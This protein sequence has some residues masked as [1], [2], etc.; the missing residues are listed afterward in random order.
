[1]RAAI[2]F[3][4]VDEGVRFHLETDIELSD[5]DSVPPSV[6]FATVWIERIVAAL[7]MQRHS[8]AIH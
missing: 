2:V 6:L 1:M 4:D 7:E 8:N 3:E 5:E